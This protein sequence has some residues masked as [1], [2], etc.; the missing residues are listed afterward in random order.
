MISLSKHNARNLCRGRTPMRAAVFQGF[1][2]RTRFSRG[3]PAAWQS[4]TVATAPDCGTLLIDFRLDELRE[5]LQ[6][7]L[8]A[9]IT[10]LHGNGI[11]QTFLHDVQFGPD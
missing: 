5:I 9:K 8:P 2:G 7:L 6:R 3:T 11:G 4:G 10:G 1:E